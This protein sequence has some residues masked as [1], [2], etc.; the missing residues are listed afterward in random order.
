MDSKK[1]AVFGIYSSV[2]KAERAVESL[3]HAGFDRG[4]VSVLVPNP[5]SVAD[6]GHEKHTKAPEGA[7]AGAAKQPHSAYPA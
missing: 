2:E 3:V 6:F 1:T 4:A 5:E 7:V